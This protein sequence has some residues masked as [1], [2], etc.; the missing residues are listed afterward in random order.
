MA[1][2]DIDVPR[3]YDPNQQAFMGV[4]RSITERY[5]DVQVTDVT[6]GFPA[7][8]VDLGF[9]YE[10]TKELYNSGRIRTRSDLEQFFLRCLQRPKMLQFRISRSH[11]PE[12]DRDHLEVKLMTKDDRGRFTYEFSVANRETGWYIDGVEEAWPEDD[13]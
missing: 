11:V 9:L 1:F 6:D 7:S 10:K 5:P 8:A 4:A 3:I 2:E 12:C 13:E